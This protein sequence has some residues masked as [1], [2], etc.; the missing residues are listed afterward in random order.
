MQNGKIGGVRIQNLVRLKSG[1]EVTQTQH[2]R[3]GKIV[4]AVSGT[5]RRIRL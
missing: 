3:R 4:A 5:T 2:Q 1:K